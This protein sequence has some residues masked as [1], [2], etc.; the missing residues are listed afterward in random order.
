MHVLINDRTTHCRNIFV[1]IIMETKTIKTEQMFYSLKE[2][3]SWSY[4]A[5]ASNTCVVH[6]QCITLASSCRPPNDLHPTQ[7]VIVNPRKLQ[8]NIV[9][10]NLYKNTLFSMLSLHDLLLSTRFVHGRCKIVRH[11]RNVL[12]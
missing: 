12:K 9:L 5:C 6:T 11:G 7:L 10:I 1:K 4:F 3:P 8:R 2:F